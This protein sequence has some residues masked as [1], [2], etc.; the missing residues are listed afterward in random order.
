MVRQRDS[1]EGEV[2]HGAPGAVLDMWSDRRKGE[3]KTRLCFGHAC[4]FWTRRPV[5]LTHGHITIL[6]PVSRCVSPTATAQLAGGCDGSWLTGGGWP[7]RMGEK[8][9]QVISAFR[10]KQRSRLTPPSGIYWHFRASA[11]SSKNK[12]SESRQPHYFDK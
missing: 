4:V 12:S 2:C 5:H 1:K 3:K 7:G 9:L 6:L 10:Y 11:T 8:E